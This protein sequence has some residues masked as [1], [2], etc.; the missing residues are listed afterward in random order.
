MTEVLARQNAKPG[1]GAVSTASCRWTESIQV[2]TDEQG[3][4]RK[5]EAILE[6]D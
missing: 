1:P 6:L 5:A 3:V 2:T 4:S